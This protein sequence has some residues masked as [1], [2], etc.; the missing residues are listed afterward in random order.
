MNEIQEKYQEDRESWNVVQTSMQNDID[1]VRN[2]EAALQLKANEYEKS[3]Q[4][5]KES[6]EEIEKTFAEMS[7]RY[8]AYRRTL[9]GRLERLSTSEL[10]LV[11]L[12]K[13]SSTC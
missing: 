6:P 2:N 5:L 10:E 7:L 4:K 1:I 8:Y 3:L 12:R 13:I 9:G 11:F